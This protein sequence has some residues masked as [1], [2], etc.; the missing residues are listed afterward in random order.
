MCLNNILYGMRWIR[1]VVVVVDVLLFE[2]HFVAQRPPISLIDV[3][4]GHY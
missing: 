3:T 1:N 4:D 2:K